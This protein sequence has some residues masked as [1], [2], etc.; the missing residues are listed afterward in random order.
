MRKLRHAAALALVGWYMMLPTIYHT[1]PLMIG[2]RQWNDDGT[3]GNSS[4]QIM[5]LTI[6]RLNV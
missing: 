1:H 6:L 4:W 2:V 3:P 5:N